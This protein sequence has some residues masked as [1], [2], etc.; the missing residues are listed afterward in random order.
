MVIG[1]ARFIVTT[2]ITGTP[3]VNAGQIG[4][5]ATIVSAQ[6]VTG[7]A[8][9]VVTLAQVSQLL[10]AGKSVTAGASATGTA[11]AGYV[12]FEGLLRT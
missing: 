10:A 12:Q 5:S 11:G 7:N 3:S 4:S 1:A 8:G 9:A 6:P 2:N